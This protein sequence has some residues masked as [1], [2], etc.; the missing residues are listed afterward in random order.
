MASKGWERAF[1]EGID[2]PEIDGA[3]L[4][5]LLD[6]SRTEEAEDDRI[7]FVMRSLE[8]EIDSAG[9]AVVAGGG[10]MAVE[11]IH[12]LE[13]CEDCGLDDILLDLDGHDCSGSPPYLI[14]DPFDLVEMEVVVESSLG[15]D[16][17]GWYLDEGRMAEYGDSF[18]YHGE[19]SLEQVYSPLWG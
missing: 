4:M 14:E 5:E 11:S 16:I 18:Y 15:G 3:L 8:A 6:E 1:G 13:G 12:A 9:P 19:P 7:S 10:I 17:G 2:V